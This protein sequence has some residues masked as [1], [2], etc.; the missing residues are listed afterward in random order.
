MPSRTRVV[1]VA[2]LTV[3]FAACSERQVS[4]P[5]PQAGPTDSGPAAPFVPVFPALAKPGQVYAE[6][7]GLYA[8]SGSQSVSRFVLYDDGTFE[9]QFARG[10]APLTFKG[11]YV[12][13]ASGV[14]F[15]WDDWETTDSW[16]AASTV[17]PADQERRDELRIRA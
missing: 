10:S 5:Q 14:R 2:A 4:D 1:G 9:L 7:Q 6:P 8:N 11:R 13:D 12:R 16:F 17:T 3:L 15:D